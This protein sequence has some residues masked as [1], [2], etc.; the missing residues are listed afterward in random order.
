MAMRVLSKEAT[1]NLFRLA[2]EK[3]PKP[4]A[5]TQQRGR[6][7]AATA[8][9]EAEFARTGMVD[10]AVVNSIVKMKLDLD[11]LYCLWAEDKLPS[12]IILP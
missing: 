2:R 10:M 11:G 7:A 4:F 1:A 12:N 5:I 9:A 6:I 8:A 3:V